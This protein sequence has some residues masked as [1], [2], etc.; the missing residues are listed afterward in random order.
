MP[1]AKSPGVLMTTDHG[2]YG[3]C[4]NLM[5]GTSQN[6]KSGGYHEISWDITS[7]NHQKNMVG[8]HRD[9]SQLLDSDN[10]RLSDDG[11]NPCC[12]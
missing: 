9:D 3:Q 5:I 8:I 4:Q 11:K 2:T 12:F 7:E 1:L 6:P 10:P